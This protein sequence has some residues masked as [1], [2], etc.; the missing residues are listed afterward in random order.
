MDYSAKI[1]IAKLKGKDNWATWKYNISALLGGSDG[2]SDAVNGTLIK[3]V[4][5]STLAG[6]AGD[7]AQS[8]YEKALA[9]S[10]KTES[11]ALLMLTTNMTEETLKKVM[12]FKTAHEV[13]KELHRLFDGESESLIYGLCLEFFGLKH[14]KE[15]DI[16]THM[17][18]IK[19][20]WNEINVEVV[21][22][23]PS[24]KL[25]EVLL[26]CKVLDTLDERYFNFKSSWLMLK[27]AEKTID[28]LTS[29]LCAFERNLCIGDSQ[30]STSKE[31]LMTTTPAGRQSRTNID[32]MVCG[33]CSKKGHRVRKCRK[34]IKDGRPPKSN[35]STSTNTSKQVQ[36]TVMD[37]LNV[38]DCSFVNLEQDDWFVDNG[39]TTHI[40]VRR[41]FFTEFHEFDSHHTVS[42]ADGTPVRALGQ[43]TVV[44]ESNVNG[45]KGMIALQEVWLVPSLKK[46]LF[47]TLAAQDRL[48]DSL[49]LSTAKQCRFEVAGTTKLIG[50]RVYKG[51]L[52]KLDMKTV[53]PTKQVASEVNATEDSRMLQLFHERFAHQDKRHVARVVKRELGIQLSPDKLKCEGCIYGKTHKK[54]FGTRE[55]ATAPGELI[56]AD[57]CGPFAESVGKNKYFVVFKDDF[58][59]YRFVYFMRKKSEVKDKLIQMLNEAKVAGHTVKTLLSDNG[60]EFVNAEVKNILNAHGITQRLT[61]P[62]TPEQNGCSERENRTLVEAAR[63]I[64]HARGEMPKELWAEL[65]NTAAYVLNRTG[66]SRVDDKVPYE[67]WHSKKPR[68]SHLKVI[69]SECYIH[70]PKERRK[71]LDKKA[72]KGTL[73]GYEMDDGYRIWSG[74][75]I[76]K[77][78]D[79]TFDDTRLELRFYNEIPID[80]EGVQNDD[81]NADHT[82][83]EEQKPRIESEQRHDDELA[84]EGDRLDIEDQ[85]YLNDE[86]K[87]IVRIVPFQNEDDD[88][89]V[90]ANEEQL[91]VV[92]P[93]IE[94]RYNL[95]DRS[96]IRPLKKLEDY[97]C[98]VGID[99]FPETFK[100]AIQMDDAND[101]KKAMASEMKSLADNNVWKLCDLPSDR[102]A[103]PCK[104]VYRIKR[105][106]DGS[107]DKYKAR[108]V[109][110][111]FKQRKG[112]DY[113]Q[114]YSPV[115]RMATIRALLSVSAKENLYLTQF[116]V[117]TAFLNGKL[118]EEIYMKQPDGFNDGTARVCKLQRSLYGL[119]Q[120]PRCWNSCFEEILLEK[121]FKQC[122]ADSCLFTKHI[123]EKKI[124]ITLYV[125][126]GFV[127]TTDKELADQFLKELSGSL[128]ITTKKASYYLGLE[129]QRR[130]NGSI[131]IKQEAYTKKILERFGMSDCNS[132]STPIER[133]SVENGKVESRFPYREA[134]GALAY[135]MTGTRPDIAYAV[136]VVSRKL[137]NP[138]YSDWLRVKR[139]FRY[140]KGTTAMGIVYGDS[141]TN[142]I[143]GYSDA[144]HGGCTDTGRSTTGVVACYG[145]AAVSWLSQRQPSVSISTTEAEI[146]AASEGARELIWLQ[147]V[148]SQL[149]HVKEVPS[150]HVDNEAAIRLAYNPEFHKRTKH[151]RIRHFFVREAVQEGLVEVKKTS[152]ADQLADILTK[153]VPKPCLLRIRDKL[154]LKLIDVGKC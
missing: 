113:E 86:K 1:E 112:I 8:A 81:D 88:D 72:I 141:T 37:A 61:M 67:L 76:L 144:D 42:T 140:L 51:G 82:F 31:S 60:G 44:V 40:A 21:K 63:S 131:L 93:E 123:G 47:S 18:K 66:P 79:I 48:K 58:S 34:W 115:A 13:W 27:Q 135:L 11:G 139:I 33:Y 74:T 136:A 122:S 69:G 124:L 71:K 36:M 142:G 49:F 39:A 98:F 152:S 146:V 84:L 134:V 28:S 25:P 64:I 150:L 4:L 16:P 154:G 92:E 105:N 5:L 75:Q 120:A 77:S 116:D 128:K 110:K 89:F 30:E 65:V 109:V 35:P 15:D 94:P 126:D 145:G 99:K 117:S 54:P 50:R 12:R 148:F 91:E 53:M 103:L 107:I 114:T 80:S 43:G 153:A 143:I 104:W 29:H 130:Q 147:R 24:A 7:A 9:K 14:R 6:A 26:V 125:D 23:D 3:P 137:E 20:I 32:E 83:Q 57:V 70:V 52:Y 2:A 121:G 108:L 10:K 106:P 62:Y 138:T 133:E 68:I 59:G 85:I 97:A 100:E 102:K 87:D 41:D 118:Q 46:N 132:V 96:T 129:I 19:N 73:V 127:A 55:R 101:W 151:I 119:K 78:R 95:R 56:H 38:E 22:L 90:D 149:T 17:S 45:K 111:G